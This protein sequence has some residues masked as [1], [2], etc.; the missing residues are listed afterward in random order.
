MEVPAI[1]SK[2]FLAWLD[3]TSLNHGINSVF[4][5]LS[6]LVCLAETRE[7]QHFNSISDIMSASFVI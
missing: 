4:I 2:V 5:H 7:I 1:C 6:C 3:V